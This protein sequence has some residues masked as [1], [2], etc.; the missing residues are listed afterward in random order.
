MRKNEE[1]GEE[2]EEE[3]EEVEGTFDVLTLVV[4]K[5]WE[6][7]RVEAVMMVVVLIDSGGGGGGGGGG[8]L[9]R[10]G[11]GGED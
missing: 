1:E 7:M 8:D 3:E 6:V 11:C 2:E 9:G 5:Q 10:N 4:A